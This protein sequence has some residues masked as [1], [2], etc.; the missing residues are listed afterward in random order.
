MSTWT[1]GGV[2]EEGQAI[3]MPTA[4]LRITARQLMRFVTPVSVGFLIIHRDRRDAEG[5]TRLLVEW[6]RICNRVNMEV[7]DRRPTSECVCH[8]SYDMALHGDTVS[9]RMGDG[10]KNLVVHA[11]W[12]PLYHRRAM[13]KT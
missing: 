11:R 4:R 9:A 10:C 13:L 8:E 6:C 12:R 7:A 2:A 1:A 5:F 3:R